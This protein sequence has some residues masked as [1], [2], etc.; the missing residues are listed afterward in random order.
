MPVNNNIGVKI[1]SDCLFVKKDENVLIVTDTI[2]EAIGR[3]LFETA[4][5][6]G[7]ETALITMKPRSKSGEEPPACVAQAM[8]GADVIIC[9]TKYSLTHTKARINASREKARIATMP[10]ITEKMYFQGPLDI[11]Y[12]QCRKFTRKYASLLSK[13]SSACLVNQGKRLTLDLSGRHG[14]ADNGVY[15]DYGEHGNLPAGEAYIAPLEGKANGEI[16]IDGV[17]GGIGVLTEPLLMKV[18]NGYV[19]EISGRH[20]DQLEKLLG[21]NQLA[22]N[23]AELGIGLNSAASLDSGIV[24]EAEKVLGTVHIALGTNAGF[25]GI[26]QAGVHLDG[27]MRAPDL[28]LD[29]LKIIASGKLVG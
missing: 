13:A 27:V 25:G 15:A 10:G 5:G 3:N 2:C 14:V 11:D 18:E 20:K 24:L 28:Y 7:F 21:D 16:A 17:M 9:P 12:E 6:L 4:L 1:L 8:L 22:Y 29:D 19:T 26:I 23:V